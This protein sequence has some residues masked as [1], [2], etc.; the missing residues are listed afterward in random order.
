[1]TVWQN[2]GTMTLWNDDSAAAWR[3]AVNR[4]G[5]VSEMS[6]VSEVSEDASILA[7]M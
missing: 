2:A 5:A 6:E 1:M 7:G 4:E 3:R